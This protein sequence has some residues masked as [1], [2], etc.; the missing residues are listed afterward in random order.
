MVK[1]DLVFEDGAQEDAKRKAEEEKGLATT[2]GNAKAEH[3]N[4]V[5]RA[6]QPPYST[7][8]VPY[9]PIPQASPAERLREDIAKGSG[10][11]SE[12]D[13]AEDYSVGT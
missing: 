12:L 7:A 3:R 13:S 4:A 6:S 10:S 9:V 8:R 2:L 1:D 5:V 11:V